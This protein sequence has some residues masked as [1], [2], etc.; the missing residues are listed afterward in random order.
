MGLAGQEV[1][2]M[3]KRALQVGQAE[4]LLF[5]MH[6]DPPDFPVLWAPFLLHFGH[7]FLVF[8]SFGFHIFGSINVLF[9]FVHF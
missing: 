2:P 4:R 5:L 6:A 1:S 7:V 9:L 8:I 3:H